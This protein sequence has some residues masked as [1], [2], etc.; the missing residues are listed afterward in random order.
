MNP[1]FTQ[2]KLSNVIAELNTL[3]SD[4]ELPHE[5]RVLARQAREKACHAQHEL[6]HYLQICGALR[7]EAE[8]A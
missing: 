5:V 6:T 8:G 7:R 4:E 1:Q 3:M 2:R